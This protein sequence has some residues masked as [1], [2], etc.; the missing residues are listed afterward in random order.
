MYR[1]FKTLALHVG[2][3]WPKQWRYSIPL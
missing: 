3:R 2:L 1:T